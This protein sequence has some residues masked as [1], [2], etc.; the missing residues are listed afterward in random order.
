M[1][2]YFSRVKYSE[3]FEENDDYSI[4]TDDLPEIYT[5]KKPRLTF[6]SAKK[7]PEQSKKA[8][9]YVRNKVELGN[10]L[11]I[12]FISFKYLNIFLANHGIQ[13]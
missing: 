8:S 9:R 5:P 10:K 4:T 12:L 2:L 6:L 1:F 3:V 11:C 7:S 13:I